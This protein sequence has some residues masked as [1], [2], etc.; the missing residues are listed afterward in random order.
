[1]EVPERRRRARDPPFKGDRCPE[2]SIRHVAVI[3]ERTPE[4]MET[5]DSL[6]LSSPR[7]GADTS[8]EGY[9]SLKCAPASVTTITSASSPRRTSSY[10]GLVRDATVRFRGGV[11]IRTG[12]RGFA[13][14]CLT[15]RPRRQKEKA[16]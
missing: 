1:M 5:H 10:P 15:T 8:A 12:V 7:F 9:R 4:P 6:P 13:G 14:P 11:R 16:Y 3:R 2:L